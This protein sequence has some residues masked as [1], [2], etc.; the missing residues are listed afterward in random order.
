LRGQWLGEM[1]FM[2]QVLF[3]HPK[4]FFFFKFVTDFFLSPFLS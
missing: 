4:F 1:V 3:E 2:L